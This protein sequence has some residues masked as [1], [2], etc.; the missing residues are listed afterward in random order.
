[1]AITW[2]NVQG[3]DSAGALRNLLSAGAGVTAGFDALRGVVQDAD[4]IGRQQFEQQKVTNTNEFLDSL[5]AR[6]Q[7]PE[8]LQAAIASG[9]VNE[10][11]QAF[12]RNIDAGAV[13][14]AADTRLANLRQQ[15]TAGRQYENQVLD[16]RD[17]TV[18]S[19]AAALALQGDPAAAQELA[20]VSDRNKGKGAQ[21][22]FNAEKD[23]FGFATDQEKEK[24][25]NVTHDLS[26][27]QGESQIQANNASMAASRAATAAS[28]LRTQ[29]GQ[30]DLNE[31]Q[32]ARGFQKGIEAEVRAHQARANENKNVLR[33]LARANPSLFPMKD[34]EVNLNGMN[35]GQREAADSLL[36]T[37]GLAPLNEI[38]SG[39]TR[40]QEN[41][42]AKLANQGAPLSMIESVRKNGD[43]FNTSKPAP[44][45]ND[46]VNAL[47]KEAQKKVFEQ[48]T[49]D[50]AGGI[51]TKASDFTEV[52][53]V[54]GPSIPKENGDLIK[55]A[56]ADYYKDGGVEIEGVKRYLPANVIA[57]VVQA[58][59]DTWS[60]FVPL[61]SAGRDTARA[62][63]AK[64]KDF[65]LKLTGAV[66][67]ETDQKV[68]AT[69]K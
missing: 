24:D 6:Y 56:V 17:Q 23:R 7:T 58:Q 67:S 44:V 50:A 55:R 36:K 66:K 9:E 60:G 13:R 11:R 35:Q 32:E 61:N 37:K 25:R 16:D 21:I 57:Q 15:G 30:M 31:R 65:K 27:R 59:H 18:L 34:G 40:A 33:D 45:G 4:V 62:L 63:A 8:A 19:R 43:W 51:P 29:I 2:R 48:H 28:N 42:L 64:E 5:Q 12:G 10:L 46:A 53:K 22:L 14:G 38:M 20:N 26:L 52:M 47:Q 68:R 49:F 1:M 41:L 3:G 69:V 54:I 39:D